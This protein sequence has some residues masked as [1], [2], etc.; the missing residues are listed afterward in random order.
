M[1]KKFVL[2]VLVDTTEKSDVFRDI[3]IGDNHTF[4]DLHEII[5]QAFEFDNAEMASFYMSNEHWD[6]GD[7]IPLMDISQ[8]DQKVPTMTEVTLN[9]KIEDS[10]QRILYVFDF[11]L[12]WCFYIEVVKIIDGEQIETPAIALSYGEAPDQYSKEPKD[13]FGAIPGMD[14]SGD[15]D[16]EADEHEEDFSGGGIY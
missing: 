1:P 7:E 5:Q 12:M 3:E 16:D 15:D 2:R 14:L 8:G 6:K 9:D 13:L 10:D 11:L 4:Q